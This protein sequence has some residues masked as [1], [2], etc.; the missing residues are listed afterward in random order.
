MSCTYVDEKGI[1][2]LEHEDAI[3][4]DKNDDPITFVGEIDESEKK[5]DG[6]TDSNTANYKK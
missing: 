5:L 4:H 3:Q 1:N 2:L 6:G